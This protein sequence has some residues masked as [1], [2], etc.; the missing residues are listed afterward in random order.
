[1]PNN[2]KKD[3]FILQAGILASAGIICRIIGLLY[4]T[5]LVMIIGDEGN[6]YY[7]SAYYAYSIVLLISS[8]SIPSAVSKVIAQRLA[9]KE[10]RNAH[11]IFCC[12]FIYVLVVG[13][14][15]SLFV[16]FG[17]G[18]LVKME[19]AVLPLKI[20]APTI[21]F[22]GIL[23]VLRGYFQAH[24]TMLQTSVSQIMEQ[25]VNAAASIGMAYM[26]VQMAEGKDATTIAS[27][28]AAGGTIGTGVGV[29]AGLLFM[30]AMYGLNRKTIKNRAEKDTG[31]KDE[32]YGD[33]FKMILLVVTP[34]IISTG[35]Y[36][37]NNFLD[38]TI[39]QHIMMDVKEIGEALVATDLSSVSKGTKISNIPIALASSMATALIPGISSDFVKGRLGGV[40]KKV[41][42]SVKV[43]ML[44]SI[45]CAVGIGVLAKPIMMVIFHQPDT[46]EISS[47]LLSCMAVSIIFYALSTLTQAILQSIGKM[48]A[49]IINASAAVVIHAGV[50]V[51]MMLFM[52]V[53]YSLYYYVFATV[54]YSFILCLLNQISVRRHL[55]YRQEAG[56]TFLRPIAASIIMGAAAYGVYQGL[57]YLCKINIIALAAAVAV[58]G[59]IYFVLVIRFKA[60]AEEEMQGMPKGYMLI[61]IA[62]K[63][64]IMKEDNDKSGK[65]GAKKKNNTSGTKKVSVKSTAPD[66]KSGLAQKENGSGMDKISGREPEWDDLSGKRQEWEELAG[67][68]SGKK[69]VPSWKT[70]KAGIIPAETETEDGDYWLD[71]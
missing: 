54:L 26:L 5:P 12:A 61:G 64:R 52:D 17:A 15:A 6:G 37:I 36:N 20:L 34:F 32:S 67:R 53:K 51:A 65:K 25:I 55:K 2:E 3:S 7:N 31:H 41:A 19:S 58:G 27:Y 21:F 46:L 68:E 60:V 45:P 48:K 42:K 50:M 22:S 35:I 30:L 23:G 8:Y 44:I 33:I 40:R 11:R 69:D 39:Y 28:G 1:M 4:N 70:P 63:L 71:D 62:K 47:V 14:I 9:T 16:F 18:I 13:G 56:K 29:L 57:F 59:M 24:K 43:T 66:K 10:Y 49:P 38:N